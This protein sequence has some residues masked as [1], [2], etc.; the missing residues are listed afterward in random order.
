MLQFY[1][2]KNKKQKHLFKIDPEISRTG[3]LTPRLLTL[4]WWQTDIHVHSVAP[5]LQDHIRKRLVCS[6]WKLNNVKM[7]KEIKNLNNTRM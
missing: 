7:V 1:T 4:F 5:S 2:K 6:W 3:C